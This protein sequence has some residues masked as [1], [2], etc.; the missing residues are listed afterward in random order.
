M[1]GTNVD[2]RPSFLSEFLCDIFTYHFD[3]IATMKM[4][5][6]IE[7]NFQHP[8]MFLELSNQRL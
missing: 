3:R 8:V 7:Q 1:S 5:E 4:Q 6:K 2:F